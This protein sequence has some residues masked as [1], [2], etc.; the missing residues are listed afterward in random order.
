[1]TETISSIPCVPLGFF[2]EDEDD[3]YGLFPEFLGCFL[4]N[5]RNI[6][7]DELQLNS[8]DI[9]KFYKI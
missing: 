8:K 6:R 1:M 7:T 9:I 3:D 5:N 2:K 4:Q